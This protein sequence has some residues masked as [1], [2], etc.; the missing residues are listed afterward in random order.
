MKIPDEVK[1]IFKNEKCH[2]LAT[3]SAEGIPNI[4]NIGGKYLRDDDSIVVVDNYMKKTVTNALSNPNV[5]ILIR[6]EKVSYQIKGKCRYV[7]SG[8]EYEEAKKWMKAVAEKYPAKGALIITVEDIFD[9]STG[10]N[11]GKNLSPKEQQC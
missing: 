10:P 7:T 5:S 6:R 8:L 4:S 9:S 2:Q 3:V 1:K 11:A